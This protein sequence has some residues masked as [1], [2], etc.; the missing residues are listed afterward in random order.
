M[1]LMMLYWPDRCPCC[2]ARIDFTAVT[3]D[4]EGQPWEG[5]YLTV[6]DVCGGLG[7]AHEWH[8]RLHPLTPRQIA[9]VR[10]HPKSDLLR[11]LCASIAASHIG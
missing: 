4:E 8:G 2:F 5:G 11:Q 9:R 10:S 7:F 3:V 6:C 1:P